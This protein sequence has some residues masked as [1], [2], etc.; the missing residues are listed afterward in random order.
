[1]DAPN[2]GRPSDD[3]ETI[4]AAEGQQTIPGCLD[5]ATALKGHVQEELG[6]VLPRQGP[7][8]RAS[9]SSRDDNIEARNF[10]NRAK[11]IRGHIVVAEWRCYMCRRRGSKRGDA[12]RGK[13]RGLCAKLGRA[14]G[15][16][17][18]PRSPEVGASQL[19][20]VPVG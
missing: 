5:Q 10:T 12:V 9:A 18:E 8:A 17:V 20:A 11:R 6:V 15:W 3:R 4:C 13:E 14:R 2:V 7:Q 19:L 1:M 16:G